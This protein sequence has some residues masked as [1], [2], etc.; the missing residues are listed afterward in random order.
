M[1]GYKTLRDG[2]M[3]MLFSISIVYQK[4]D[5]NNMLNKGLY[6]AAVIKPL[7][8]TKLNKRLKSSKEIG[9]SRKKGNIQNPK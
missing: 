2:R 9:I 8:Q 7:H 6:L 1:T 4:K 3:L 5:K